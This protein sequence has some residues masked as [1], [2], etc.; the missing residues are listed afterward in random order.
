MREFLHLSTQEIEELTPLEYIEYSTYCELR[1]M[2]N[3][4]PID[5]K[6]NSKGQR[7]VVN[8][9]LSDDDLYNPKNR[10]IKY[11]AYATPPEEK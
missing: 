5:P 4:P 11:E 10:K 3:R 1:L 6:K 9:G 7:L 8:T 2:M